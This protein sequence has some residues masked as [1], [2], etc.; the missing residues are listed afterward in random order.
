ML[1]P[2]WCFLSICFNSTKS[3]SGVQCHAAR[4]VPEPEGVSPTGM[5]ADKSERAPGEGYRSSC[6]TGAHPF[7][8][9]I[10]LGTSGSAN[11]TQISSFKKCKQ[12]VS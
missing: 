3:T 4:Q 2:K 8:P 5:G 11:I 1:H 9:W 6:F 12:S 10:P 7:A